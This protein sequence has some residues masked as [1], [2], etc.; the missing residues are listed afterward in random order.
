M[1]AGKMR[2]AI[3]RLLWEEQKNWEVCTY[4]EKEVLQWTW[5]IKI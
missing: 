1:R 4:L 3:L 5:K 2:A